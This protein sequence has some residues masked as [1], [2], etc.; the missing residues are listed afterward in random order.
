MNSITCFVLREQ[1]STP[2]NTQ[3]E[4]RTVVST[5]KARKLSIAWPL[6]RHKKHRGYYTGFP[7]L[8]KFDDPFSV[9]RADQVKHLLPVLLAQFL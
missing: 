4:T 8:Y 6:S 9:H 1:K 7:Y 3:Y 5:K 2:R